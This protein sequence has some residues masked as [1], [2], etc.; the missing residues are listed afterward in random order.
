MQ[1]SSGEQLE[2]GNYKALLQK[3]KT[4]FDEKH[5]GKKVEY[6]YQEVGIEMQKF[7][8]QN[9]WFLFTKYDLNDIKY[10]F[11]QCKKY[12]KPHIGYLLA[13]IKKRSCPQ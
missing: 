6:E 4:A 13:V 7:F 3:R 9:I 5:E 12:E 8:K 11:D 10:A 1:Y 2:L